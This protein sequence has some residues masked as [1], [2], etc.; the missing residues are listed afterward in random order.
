M[1]ICRSATRSLTSLRQL[2]AFA[3]ASVA[4]VGFATAAAAQVVCDGPV[5]GKGRASAV[6]GGSDA[7][8][9]KGNLP[10]GLARTRAIADWQ[11]KVTQKCPGRS[12]SW[13]RAKAKSIDC[14]S[15]ARAATC[16]AR[17]RPAR[18]LF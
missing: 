1:T 17:A 16:V 8:R 15:E 6:T 7:T 11:T 2:T 13:L 12:N 10:A 18:K 4:F 14:N 3:L 9:F 5:I